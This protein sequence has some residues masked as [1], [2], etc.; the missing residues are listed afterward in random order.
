[1][2]TP[3]SPEGPTVARVLAGEGSYDALCGADQAI[4][5][6]AWVERIAALRESLDYEAEFRESGL[7]WSEA[8]T[9]GNTVYRS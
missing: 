8:D 9:E 3:P 6:D 2:T 1:M 7:T 4:V 5:R